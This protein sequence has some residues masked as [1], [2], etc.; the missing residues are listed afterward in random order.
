MPLE[1]PQARVIV[2]GVPV[3]GLV[4]IEVHAPG[5]FSAARFHAKFAIGG[6]IGW[7]LEAFAALGAEPIRIEL[8]TDGYGYAPV[9]SGQIENIRVDMANNIAALSGRDL[10]ALLIDSEISESFVNQTASQIAETIALRHGLT[11][12]VTQTMQ[13]IG[14]YYQIDH[15]R[16]AL[17][18]GSRAT[19][20]W[21]L[22]CRLA[23]AEQFNVS[24]SDYVLNFGPEA[25]ASTALVDAAS[26][27]ALEV[28][29]ITALPS[30]VSVRSWNSK[31][32]K[33]QEYSTGAGVVTNLV[34]PNASV[35]QAG[36]YAAAYLAMTQ[37]HGQVLLGKMPGDVALKL[38]DVMVLTGTNSNLDTQYQVASLTRRLNDN[39][40]FVQ[41]VRAYAVNF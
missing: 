39:E 23:E 18:A 2:N 1:G 19:T 14:Q 3:A 29:K 26:F 34:R 32:K 22:L 36:D 4:A 13:P 12:R 8:S 28:D 16:L 31:S 10:T 15:A 35:E 30:A 17:N 7:T 27:I 33:M 40:G 41:I 38:G 9:L 37:R 24:V 5:G 25:G 6:G 11:P 20:E 21:N